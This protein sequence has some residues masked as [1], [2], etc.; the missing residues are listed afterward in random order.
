MSQEIYCE[1]GPHTVGSVMKVQNLAHFSFVGCEVEILG[2]RPSYCREYF[3]VP[4]DKN[5]A[6]AISDALESFRY[7]IKTQQCCVSFPKGKYLVLLSAL[8]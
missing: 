4:T 3:S 1:L 7:V 8:L 6:D 5:F 2:V